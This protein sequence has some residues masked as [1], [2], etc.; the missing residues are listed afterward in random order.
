LPRK[1]KNVRET[2]RC[3]NSTLAISAIQIVNSRS[4]INLSYVENWAIQEA[5]YR[6]ATR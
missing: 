2:R 4:F 6:F 3:S 5:E 1:N